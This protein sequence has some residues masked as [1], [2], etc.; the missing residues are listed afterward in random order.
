MGSSLGVREVTEPQKNGLYVEV[1]VCKYVLDLV[2]ARVL[3]G[4]EDFQLFDSLHYSPL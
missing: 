2:M 3:I 4:H 1:D